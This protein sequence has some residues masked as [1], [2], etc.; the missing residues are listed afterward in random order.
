ME[1]HHVAAMLAHELPVA[2]SQ[3]RGGPP[4]ILHQPGLA[5]RLDYFAVH[6]AMHV[7]APAHT[8]GWGGVQSACHGAGLQS[9]IGASTPRRSGTRESGSTHMASNAAS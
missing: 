6:H 5:Q 2:A 3:R 9:G 7:I 4:A 8:R 1:D